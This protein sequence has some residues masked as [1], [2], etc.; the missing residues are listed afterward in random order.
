MKESLTKVLRDS[1]FAGGASTWH[2]DGS[3]AILVVNLQ[4][5]QYGQQ[6]YVNLGVWLNALGA[7]KKPKENQCHVQIRATSLP[8]DGVKRFD[9]ALN[10]EDPAMTS[11]QR[12]AVIEEFMRGDAIPFLESCGTLNGIRSALDGGKLA[13][14][15]V[16]G[17]VRDLIAAKG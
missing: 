14:A 17:S 15:L 3:E 16:Y 2:K 10:L 11:D 5:S 6:Y 12:E 8:A 4:K 9:Q 1:G 7:A 13:R